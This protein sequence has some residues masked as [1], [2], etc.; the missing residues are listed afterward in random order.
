MKRKLQFVTFLTSAIISVLGSIHMHTQVFK[1]ADC[2]HVLQYRQKV[3]KREG[4]Q[5]CNIIFFSLLSLFLLCFTDF[6]WIMIFERF[7]R[8]SIFSTFSF[9]GPS[10]S[11]PYFITYSAPLILRP[12]SRCV[13][14]CPTLQYIPDQMLTCLFSVLKI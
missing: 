8:S 10:S 7:H 3:Y 12:L 14:F 5:K 9:H 6:L 1:C 13:Q 2:L 11:P 4:N